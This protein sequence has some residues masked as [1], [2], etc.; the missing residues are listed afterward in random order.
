[1]VP[2]DTFA[3]IAG[4]G[5][6]DLV[7]ENQHSFKRLGPVTT[8]FGL[9]SPLYRARLGDAHFLFLPRH[10]EPGQETA[11]PWVNYRANIYALKEHG[12][13]RILAWSGPAAVNLSLSVGQYLLPHDLVDDTAGRESSFFK[14]TGLGVIRQHPIFCGEM[15]AAAESTLRMQGLDYQDHGVYV[16][17][18]GPRQE[19][20][21]EVRR[22]RSWGG[23]LAGM[24]LVPEVFL[25][26]E[27]EMCYLSLCCVARHAEG[28]KEREQRPG[29]LLGGV[30]EQAESEALEEARGRLLG[31]AASLSRALPDERE[32]ACAKV[33][34]RYREAGRIDDDWHTWIGK[35]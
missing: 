28:I 17:T 15:R 34:D 14:G 23:D 30:L 20:A 32:C 21:A 33:M 1:M 8:P 26:R 25:A 6:L 16:C 11:A 3:L 2:Q 31:I 35:P 24:T 18:S 10:G 13:W 12:V 19:T 5:A 4:T 22:M 29:E 7:R 27:L 9:S